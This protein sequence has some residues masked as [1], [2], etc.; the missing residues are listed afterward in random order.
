MRRLLSIL[1]LI[2]PVTLAAQFKITGKVLDT[3]NTKPIVG[4]SVFLNNTS[5]G[6]TT[7]NNGKFIINNIRSGQ[8]ELTVSILGYETYVQKILINR[9]IDIGDLLLKPREVSLNEV[10]IKADKK[11]S[12]YYQVFEDIFLGTGD[13][14]RRCKILNPQALDIYHDDATRSIH[15][16]SYK[17]LEIENNALGYK[18]K[19]L[20]QSFVLDSTTMTF[21]YKGSVMFSEM[22][23]TKSQQ[24]KWHE[25]RQSVYK[26]SM[27]HFL[28]SCMSGDLQDA[29]FKVVHF[30]KRKIIDPVRDSINIVDVNMRIDYYKKKAFRVKGQNQKILIDSINHLRDS[31]IHL[32]AA[33]Q[34]DKNPLEL[35]DF[36]LRTNIRG[37][38]ALAFKDYVFVFYTKKH[39]FSENRVYLPPGMPDYQTTVLSLRAQNVFLIPMEF[40]WIRIWF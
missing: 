8:Y 27:M 39:D 22:T 20:L 38:Y 23:G 10:K 18:I 16:S 29:G 9:D 13:Y 15:A 2:L 32:N 36:I 5:V 17:F 26:G 33:D 30:T 1:M 28:R 35:T 37:V 11:L 21:S 6:T 3:G 31:V 12:R 19:Y 14:A 7:Q 25:N 40:F 24:E 4:A 34:I